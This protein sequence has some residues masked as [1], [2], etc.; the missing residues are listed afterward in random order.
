MTMNPELQRNIWLELA[1]RRLIA[2]PIILGLIFWMADLMGGLVALQT[3]TRTLFYL[4]AGFWGA[5]LAAA[6]VAS[7]IRDGTWD[8]QRMAPIGAWRM[9][10]GKLFGATAFAWYGGLLSLAVLV[11]AVG[12]RSAMTQITIEVLLLAC[13]LILGVVLAHAVSLAASLA[14]LRKQTARRRV[15]VTLCQIFGLV[16]LIVAAWHSEWSDLA[17]LDAPPAQTIEF[18]GTAFAAQPFKLISLAVFTGWAMLAVYRM[19]QSEL[20]YRARPWAWIAFAL[21]IM[22]YGTGLMYRSIDALQASAFKWLV[23]PFV[24]AGVAVYLAFFLEMKSIVG[25]R[26]WREALRDGGLQRLWLLTPNWLLSFGLFLAIGVVLALTL[27]IGTETALE[28]T[29][30]A[31]W[32]DLPIKIENIAAST[33]VAMML[34]VARDI[35]LLLWLNLINPQGRADM[36]GLLYLAI[37]YAVLPPLLTALGAT[38]LLTLVTP[39]PSG[40]LLLA[41]GPVALEVAALAYFTRRAWIRNSP[42][43]TL[44]TGGDHAEGAA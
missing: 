35:L 4:V 1:P 26:K 21:F 20:L 41:L 14:F 12:L 18:F 9:S 15:P 28:R 36:S 44:G 29:K 8:D 31:Q 19:M 3:A 11:I 32:I 24:T 17:R 40:N 25:F 30:V 23:F 2:M 38:G 10:W 7:E 27:A 39:Y 6:A 42:R 34:F 5:R 22:V 33:V 16:T 43:D 13:M 37:L